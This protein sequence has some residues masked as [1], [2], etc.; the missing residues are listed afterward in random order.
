MMLIPSGQNQISRSLNET[1]FITFTTT[2]F[3][4]R[5]YKFFSG[6]FTVNSSGKPNNL[7]HSRSDNLLI[8]LWSGTKILDK[9]V[10]TRVGALPSGS[11]ILLTSKL[12]FPVTMLY[13]FSKSFLYSLFLCIFPNSSICST[14]SLGYS[15][16]K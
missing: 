3:P 14:I 2:V 8:P 11:R 10:A 12:N 15:N 16:F 1:F 13:P 4:I 6:R 9:S 7:K 5:S